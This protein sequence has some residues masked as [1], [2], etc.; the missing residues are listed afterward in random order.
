[1]ASRD[2]LTVLRSVLRDVSPP[3]EEDY[4]LTLSYVCGAADCLPLPYMVFLTLLLGTDCKYVRRPAEKTAWSIAFRFK[5]V[6]FRLEHGKLGMRI[7]TSNDPASPLVDDLVQVL[8]RAFPVGD[9]AL[10]P[11]V[12]QQVKAGN[13]TVPNRH[14]LFR[15]RFEFFRERALEAFGCPCPS[16]DEV[17]RTT[18][19]DD[20][21]SRTVDVF[22]SER[23]G[24]F[25]GTAT[26]DAY[27]GWLEHVLVLLFPFVDYDPMND[28]LVA[29]IG[30]SWT[31]KLKRIWDLADDNRAK[32]LYDELREI[33]ERFRNSAAHGGFEKGDASLGVHI[34][35]IGAVPAAMSRFMKSIHYRLFPLEEASFADTCVLFDAVDS[36]LRSGRTRHGMR[37]AESGLDVAFD[38]NSRLEYTEAMKSDE[39]FGGLLDRLEHSEETHVNMDW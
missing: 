14:H 32:R 17:L 10:Q 15:R 3:F 24:F 36:H 8:H 13:V 1:M 9:R 25:L 33:K 4:R 2:P 6:P 35:G 27:F 39:D 31:D 20:G 19:A 37:Y 21:K 26:I 18:P 34:P 7:A 30:G 28:D 38:G 11:V 29:F 16:L 23:E 22:K 12:D 5:G